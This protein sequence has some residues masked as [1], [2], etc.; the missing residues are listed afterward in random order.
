ML[1]CENELQTITSLPV[2]PVFGGFILFFKMQF[3]SHC[4]KQ[5]ITI[6]K[7]PNLHI[8]NSNTVLLICSQED[9]VL[10]EVQK[11]IQ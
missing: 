3:S 8:R 6:H 10:K 5:S 1:Y 11:K 4:N 9:P 7:L 2:S